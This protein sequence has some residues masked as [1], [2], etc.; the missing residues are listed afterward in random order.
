[1]HSSTFA[2]ART[3]SPQRNLNWPP[4]RIVMKLPNYRFGDFALDAVHSVL[5]HH[6][7]P[8]AL[9]PKPIQ[10]LGLLVERAGS[11]VG[12]DELMNALWPDG[13]VEEGNLTQYI[14]LLRGV[15]REGG[16]ARAIE[17]VPRRGYRFGET[18]ERDE[19][20]A[21]RPRAIQRSWPRTLALSLCV[22]L[23][24]APAVQAPPAFA[25]LSAESQR[26]YALGRFHWNMRGDGTPGGLEESV[27]D[28]QGVVARDPKNPLGYAG[29][30]DAYI[31]IYDYPCDERGCAPIAAQ[32]LASAKRAVALGPDSAE[33][34]TSLAMALHTLVGDDANAD[35]E[36]RR[37][38]AIDPEYATAHAWYGMMLTLHGDFEEARRQVAAALRLDPVSP[39]SY[40]WLAR[41]SYYTHRYREAA[42]YAREAL[43]LEPHRF[44]TRILLGLALSNLGNSTAA[45][46]TF[47]RL[48]QIGGDPAQ[49]RALIAGAYAQSGDRNRARALLAYEPARLSPDADYAADIALAWLAAGDTSRALAVFEAMPRLDSMH[50]RFLAYD[51]RLDPVRLDPRFAAWTRLKP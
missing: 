30:A 29:L 39:A 1:M 14:Y 3:R 36:F 11:L 51:P 48:A 26:L 5:Y 49:V 32:A 46:A 38:L 37:A 9:G 22:L 23:L 40:A 18:V 15:L 17:T 6:G 35:R 19:P 33:A 43:A 25:R 8:V 16:L 24:A 44:E 42:T 7:N 21:P 31:G 28:F 2:G 47:N 12:K 50:H 45:V 4:W 13:F 10:L 20:P 34:H 41:D 27:R